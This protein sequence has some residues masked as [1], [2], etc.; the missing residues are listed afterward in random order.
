[1]HTLVSLLLVALVCSV[2]P[3]RAQSSLPKV[4]QRP[5]ESSGKDENIAKNNLSKSGSAL[6][7]T[8]I[9]LEELGNWRKLAENFQVADFENSGNLLLRF[10]L[11]DGTRV[12]AAVVKLGTMT[13]KPALGEGTQPTSLIAARNDA[14]LAVNGGYFNLSNGESASFVEKD[15]KILADPRLNRALVEN[16][17]LKP[18]LPQIF[19]R[20]ELRILRGHGKGVGQGGHIIAQIAGHNEQLPRGCKLE[21]ALQGGPRLLPELNAREEAFLRS[22]ADENNCGGRKEV[23]SIGVNRTAARTA[24]GVTDDGYL[25]I[26]AV[27]GKGQDEFSSGLTL[28]QTALLLKKLGAT[29]ALNLDGGTSTTFVAAGEGV[30]T[31]THRSYKMLIGRNPETRVCSALLVVK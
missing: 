11:Q 20:S 8:K 23:D 27:A 31:K 10:V 13:V 12:A 26:V 25:I 5:A 6:E 4:A 21:W 9:S 29:A 17:R 24:V 3:A 22:E 15:G 16:H 1:M 2:C 14:W 19:A 18:F 30:A 28:P 7:P